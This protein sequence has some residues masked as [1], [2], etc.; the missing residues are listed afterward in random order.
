[1]K[2][3]PGTIVRRIVVEETT[4]RTDAYCS[5]CLGDEELRRRPETPELHDEYEIVVPREEVRDKLRHAIAGVVH[6]GGIR[7]EIVGY[8]GRIPDFP[9][10]CVGKDGL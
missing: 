10:Q 7:N 5:E 8:R 3:V 2:Q 6:S 4:Y 1:M 9:E